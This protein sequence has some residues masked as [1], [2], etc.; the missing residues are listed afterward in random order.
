MF[1]LTDYVI[2]I[3]VN[4]L[5]HEDKKP[6]NYFDRTAMVWIAAL[7]TIYTDIIGNQHRRSTIQKQAYPSSSVK[8]VKQAYGLTGTKFDTYTPYR[9][10]RPISID[11]KVNKFDEIIL[12]K[13]GLDIDEA[14]KTANIYRVIP[15]RKGS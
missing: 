13:D 1:G 14:I 2:V 15:D 4:A 9:N 3:V 5:K 12:I 10:G 8:T 7:R 11:S 6:T